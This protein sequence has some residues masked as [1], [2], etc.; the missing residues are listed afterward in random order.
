MTGMMA[1]SQT[2]V[3]S[4]MT[5]RPILPWCPPCAGSS[6]PS[7][8]GWEAV[9]LDVCPGECWGGLG[10]YGPPPSRFGGGA[11]LQNQG[12]KNGGIQLVLVSSSEATGPDVSSLCDLREGSTLLRGS[13][14]SRQ[15]NRACP[16]YR[17]E[18]RKG[19]KVSERFEAE[20]LH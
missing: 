3:V 20:I 2:L 6:R 12:W 7:S 17:R 16:H 5:G 10:L 8:D 14:C 4:V 9:E 15:R 13:L 19:L 1:A 11:D 18:S